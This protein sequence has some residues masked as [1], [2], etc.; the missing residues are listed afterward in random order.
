MASGKKDSRKKQSKK[1]SLFRKIVR[2]IK[3]IFIAFFA[4]SLFFVLLF[5]FV[6]PPLTTFMAYQAILQTFSGKNNKV[7][8]TWVDIEDISPKMIR[9]VIAAEDN[10]FVTHWGIDTKAIKEAVEHNKDGGNTHG[11]STISQQTAKNV[12]LW[13]SRSFF[14]KG[15]EFYFTMLIEGIWGKKR[16]MEVYLNVIETGKGFYGVEKAAQ[17][18]FNTRSS[19]LTETQAALIAATLPSPQ[20]YNPVNPGNYLASR[21]DQIVSLMYKIETLQIK[22]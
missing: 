6:N 5:R 7:E 3:W 21:R 15:L 16:I 1:N 14:R 8:K 13:P 12:F 22:K 9:A 17:K 11:A 18:Y 2:W 10:R 19:N 20:R 4:S